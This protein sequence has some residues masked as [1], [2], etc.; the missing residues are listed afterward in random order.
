MTVRSAPD[1]ARATSTLASLSAQLTPR[2][3]YGLLVVFCIILFFVVDAVRAWSGTSQ[4]GRDAVASEL[5]V[6]QTLEP[7][8]VWQARF[9]AAQAQLETQG[10]GNWSASTLGE[11]AARVEQALRAIHA[12][13]LSDDVSERNALLQVDISDEAVAGPGGLLLMDF[14][15]SGRVD[16]GQ[17]GTFLADLTRTEPRLQLTDVTMS[18]PSRRL[19]AGVSVDG[20]VLLSLP[21]EAARADGG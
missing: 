2:V 17:V 13:N 1:T 19:P 12:N 15:L 3:Q 6:L 10:R 21:V 20:Y 4:D 7:Q 14:S 16:R 18:L 11:A 5:R 8:E 9:D